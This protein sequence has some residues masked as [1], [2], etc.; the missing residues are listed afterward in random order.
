M[1]MDAYREGDRVMIN[2]DVPGVDADSVELT[3]EKNVVSVTA[4]RDSLFPEDAEVLASERPQ[5][6]FS[7]QLIL[8]DNLDVDRVEAHYS[9]GVLTLTI[10]VA[11]QAKPRKLTVS[12]DKN[13][14]AIDVSS[15]DDTA[16]AKDEGG[17]NGA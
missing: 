3:V 7:R 6:T 14:D 16:S 17:T 2:F 13:R 4:Q 8:G 15:T 12:S 1:P 11:E 5:G 10:P 9:S